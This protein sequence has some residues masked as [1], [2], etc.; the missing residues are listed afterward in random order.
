[1]RVLGAA[2][3]LTLMPIA[4]NAGD[5]LAEFRSAGGFALQA[6]L[7]SALPH[8]KQVHADDLSGERRTTFLCMRDRFVEKN[9]VPISAGL[10]AWTSKV[11]STYRTYWTLVMLGTKPADV[12]E[13]D[14]AG[15]LAK[16]VKF[17]RTMKDPAMDALEPLL[18]AQLEARGY[19]ALFGV[20]APLREFML[21]RK[22]EDKTYD[23]DLPDGHEKVQVAM[24]DDFVSFGWLGFATCDFLHTGGWANSE[25]LFAVRSSYDLDSE[26]FHVSYLA[27]EG[28]HFSDYRR[29]PGLE[30]PD[31]EYRAKLVEIAKAKSTLFDLLASFESNG[32]DSRE[33]PHPWANRQVITHLAEKLLNGAAPSAEAWKRFSVEQLNTA[34]ADLLEQDNKRREAKAK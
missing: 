21:W 7:K 24:M 11:V 3:L 18:Q 14:L 19:H 22:Q 27:H 33:T 1:M 13:H 16:L 4:G 6:D 12:A 5:S 28:Q 34:A 30:Q 31:L 20:T 8:L 2:V 15:S 29:F 9:P 26:S 10:D 23:I 17:D 32:A 25:R